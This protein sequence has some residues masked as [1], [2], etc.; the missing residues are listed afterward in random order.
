MDRLSVAVSEVSNTV[1]TYTNLHVTYT[2][3]HLPKTKLSDRKK[4]GNYFLDRQICL[5]Y[6]FLP[7]IPG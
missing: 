6:A 4:E 1:E 7:L 3:P 5:A 2:N